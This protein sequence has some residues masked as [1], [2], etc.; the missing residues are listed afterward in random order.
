MLS[1]KDPIVQG[2]DAK[3]RPT[4]RLVNNIEVGTLTG[5]VALPEGECATPFV[6]VFDDGVTPNPIET[7]DTPDDDDPIATAM[8]EERDNGVGPVTYDYT[9]GFLLTGDYVAAFTCD[10]ETFDPEMTKEANIS[11]GNVTEVSFP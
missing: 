11:A 8:V 10:G 1:M 9:V 4:V 6:F 3:L 5:D 7:G 2:A